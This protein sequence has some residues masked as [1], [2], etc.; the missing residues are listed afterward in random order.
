[1]IDFDD[2]DYMEDDLSMD[3]MLDLAWELSEEEGRPFDHIMG[4]LLG[5]IR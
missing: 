5:G 4:E 2:M 3:E 1:M